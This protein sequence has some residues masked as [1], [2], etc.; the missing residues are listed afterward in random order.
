VIITLV[1]PDIQIQ[2]SLVDPDGKWQWGAQGIVGDR[3]DQSQEQ[4]TRNGYAYYMPLM[5][6]DQF[7]MVSPVSRGC[8]TR[9]FG[10]ASWMRTLCFWLFDMELT[11]DV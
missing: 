1:S 10:V 3:F 8:A 2:Q 5:T 9:L 7:H 11:R 6:Q 4:R